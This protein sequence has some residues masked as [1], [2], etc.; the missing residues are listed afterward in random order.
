MR[1]E[2]KGKVI[3]QKTRAG[4]E[5][6][7]VEAWGT[8][9]D[10]EDDLGY[11]ATLYDGSFAI[12]FDEETFRD[13]FR[14]RYPDIYLDVYCGDELLASTEEYTHWRMEASATTQ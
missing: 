8:D 1:Y 5:G 12:P 14:D 3:D 13:L 11:T 6:V 7:R 10:I 9:L 2:I 4:V